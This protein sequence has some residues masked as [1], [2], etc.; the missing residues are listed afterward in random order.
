MEVDASRLTHLVGELEKLSGDKGMAERVLRKSGLTRK[1]AA[2]NAKHYE[3][4][5]EALFVREACDAL[6]DVTFGARAGSTWRVSNSL[7]GY[8]SKYSKDLRAAVEN[9]ARFH[10]IIDPAVQYILKVSGN[11]ASFEV[12]WKDPSYSKFHRHTEFLLFGV[13]SRMRAITQT[14]FFPIEMRFD[15]EVRKS[16]EKFQ[17]LAGFPVV[18]GSESLEIILPL[19]ALDLAIPT[20]DLRLREHLTEYGER[21]LREQVNGHQTLRSRIEGLLTT[22]LPARI[23]SA[24]E[25]AA[26]LGM[27]P[28]TFARRLKEE[29]LTFRLIVDELRFDLAKTFMKDDMA[30]SEIAFALGYADQAA[31]STAFK[32]WTGVAPRGYSLLN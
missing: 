19:S 21:L 15:H 3:Y 25:V 14:N 28:R 29:R 24:D 1:D 4:K 2:P 18:F 10:E 32:R 30:F 9:T 27:S 22:S 23:L 20:Y 31:F 6:G 13:L 16:A 26:S 12:T 11:A 5:K 7:T 17:K 8:I